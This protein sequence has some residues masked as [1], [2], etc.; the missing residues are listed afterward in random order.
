MG[1]LAR[2]ELGKPLRV[3]LVR[4]A[5][6]RVA[7]VGRVALRLRD[8]LLERLLTGRRPPELNVHPGR[9]LVDAVDGPADL[10]HDLADVLRTDDGR[11]G[12]GERLAAPGRQLGI[13]AH[14][15]LELGAM[16]LD[17]VAAAARRSH[18]PTQQDV[19]DEDEIGRTVLAEGARVRLDPGLELCARAVLNAL[20]LVALIAVQHEHGQQPADVRRGRSGAAEIEAL[21]VRLL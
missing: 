12:A 21:G 17:D 8:Q 19:V 2:Q 14:R 11:R 6:V 3:A 10:A 5:L 4:E 1:L 18:G 16:R 20:D 7:G 9:H 15:V 13:A